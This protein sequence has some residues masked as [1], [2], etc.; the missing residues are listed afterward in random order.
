MRFK[1]LPK[2]LIMKNR[3]SKLQDKLKIEKTKKD[4]KKK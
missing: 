1:N 2:T 3:K 4:T